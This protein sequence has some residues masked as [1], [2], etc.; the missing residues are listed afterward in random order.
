ME[1]VEEL[2]IKILDRLNLIEIDPSGVSGDDAL[3]GDGLGLDSL[4]AL[5]LVVIFENDYGIVLSD[6][7]SLKPHL[8]SLNTL[9]VFIQENRKDCISE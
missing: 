8:K 6:M 3:F 4:D 5:E 1:L 9:A 2:K 7:E